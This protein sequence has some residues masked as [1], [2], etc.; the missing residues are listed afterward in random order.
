MA[1]KKFNSLDAL[2]NDIQKDINKAIPEIVSKS[3]DAFR[4][5]SSKIPTSDDWVSR[6]DKN[7]GNPSFEGGEYVDSDVY[8]D[9]DVISIYTTNK[10]YGELYDR[11]TLLIDIIESGEGYEFGRWE[12]VERPVTSVA[13]DILEN[14]NTVEKILDKYLK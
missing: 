6:Y 11:N 13:Y 12:G 9:N 7:D 2:L 4:E 8:I 5:A 10:I 3:D 14:D 1:R